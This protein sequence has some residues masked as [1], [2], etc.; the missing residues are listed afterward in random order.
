MESCEREGERIEGARGI[1]NPKRE[2]FV[3]TKAGT[4]EYAW[5]RPRSSAHM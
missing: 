2:G 5:D 3:E 4:R 1:K